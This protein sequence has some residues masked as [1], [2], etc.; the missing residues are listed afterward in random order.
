MIVTYSFSIMAVVI[1]IYQGYKYDTPKDYGEPI[2]KDTPPDASLENP[3]YPPSFF[4]F[5]LRELEKA[6]GKIQRVCWVLGN[7][8]VPTSQTGTMH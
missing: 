7:S 3:I 8:Y 2:F 5:P 1:S 4:P 6:S